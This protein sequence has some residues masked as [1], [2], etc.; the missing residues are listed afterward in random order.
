MDNN[1]ST[2]CQNSENKTILSTYLFIKQ[3][4]KNIIWQDFLTVTFLDDQCDS[5]IYRRYANVS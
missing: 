2:E 5:D 1:C 3:M 4:F